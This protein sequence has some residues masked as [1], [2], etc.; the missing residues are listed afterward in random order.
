MERLIPFD[1]FTISGN[2]NLKKLITQFLIK[3]ELAEMIFKLTACRF[4]QNS[5]GEKVGFSVDFK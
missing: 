2:F 4:K 3:L 1:Y 5:F